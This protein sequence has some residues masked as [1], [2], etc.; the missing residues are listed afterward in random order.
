MKA[1]L[2]RYSKYLLLLAVAVVITNTTNT[3]Y[4]AQPLSPVQ[5]IQEVVEQSKAYIVANKDKVSE[6]DMIA[7]LK[8]IVS[9]VFD[10]KEMARRCLGKNWSEGTPEQQQEFIDLF[11]EMLA[12][13]YMKKV[14]K[15]ID[16][17]EIKYPANSEE[18]DGNKATV[19]T[20]IISDGD[21]I[22]VDYRMLQ[23]TDLSWWA[24]DVIIEN[25]GLVSNYRSEFGDIIKKSGFNGLIKALKDRIEKTKQANN[26]TS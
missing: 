25:I 3:A 22:A 5:R 6:A 14:V 20:I 8:D 9:P 12:N 24:Y 26:K 7:K 10:F 21:T 4:A 1:T 2:F 17:A 13:A 16:E 19:K 11:S 18:I 23:R 15:S